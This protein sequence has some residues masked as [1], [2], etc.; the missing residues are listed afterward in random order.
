MN[1]ALGP[2]LLVAVSLLLGGLMSLTLLGLLLMPSRGPR[3]TATGSEHAAWRDEPLI[4]SA[5]DGTAVVAPE[6]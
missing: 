3:P 6:R 1:L 2:V 4:A 5:R